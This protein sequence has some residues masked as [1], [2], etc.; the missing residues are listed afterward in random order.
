MKPMIKQWWADESASSSVEY[1]LLLAVVAIAS[2]GAFISLRNKINSAINAV[3]NS[4][5]P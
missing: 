2:L 1:S 3:T 4:L 5:G